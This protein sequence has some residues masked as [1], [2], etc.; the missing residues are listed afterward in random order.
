MKRLLNKVGTESDI[1]LLK[2]DSLVQKISVV[3]KSNNYS[4]KIVFL[5]GN[6]MFAQFCQSNGETWT[7]YLLGENAY[8][9]DCDKFNNGSGSHWYRTIDAY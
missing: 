5:N 4:K 3:N 9:K 6:P 2:Q 1:F 7:L 8:F